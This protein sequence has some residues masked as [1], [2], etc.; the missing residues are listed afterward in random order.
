MPRAIFL[1]G[2]RAVGDG[3]HTD[4]SW[5]L[6]RQDDNGNRFLVSVKETKEEAQ[7]LL[8]SYEKRGH[9]QYYF[10]EPLPGRYIFSG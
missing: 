8:E 7:K 10:I 3:E 5:A 4:C 2:G 9:K 6:W 1:S